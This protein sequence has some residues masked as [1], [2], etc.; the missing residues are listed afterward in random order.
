MLRLASRTPRD[1]MRGRTILSLNKQL[2][3]HS[4]PQVQVKL[5]CDNF[6]TVAVIS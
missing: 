5:G 2:P 6:E 1:M 3:C 4:L